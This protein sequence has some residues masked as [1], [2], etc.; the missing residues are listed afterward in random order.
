MEHTVFSKKYMG[1]VWDV[2]KQ[3]LEGYGF[4]IVYNQKYGYA[5]NTEM[6]TY[7]FTI[8]IFTKLATIVYFDFLIL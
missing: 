7:S 3:I 4:M 2:Y 6:I 8:Y 5:Q 1:E